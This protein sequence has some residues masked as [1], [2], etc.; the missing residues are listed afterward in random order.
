MSKVRRTGLPPD[1]ASVMDLH[2]NEVSPLL[3]SP[4]GYFVYKITDK[5]TIAVTKAHD[6]ILGAL[7]SQ[8]LQESRQALQQASTATLDDKYFPTPNA[9]PGMT[10]PPGMNMPRGDAKPPAT[11][12]TLGPK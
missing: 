6:E 3:S 10:M 1:Q 4:T 7:R 8:R 9:G 12:P 5:D 11:P 2:S